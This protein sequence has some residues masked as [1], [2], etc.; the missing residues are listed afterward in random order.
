V[1]WI[2]PELAAACLVWWFDGLRSQERA[3]ESS[4]RALVTRIPPTPERRS[5][6]SNR[7]WPVGQREERSASRA[8]RSWP[9]RSRRASDQTGPNKERIATV[10]GRPRL[11]AW[12][13]ARG[14][15]ETRCSKDL[16]DRL[17]TKPEKAAASPLLTFYVN[18]GN[19]GAAL[20]PEQLQRIYTGELTTPA[21][22]GLR[23]RA[24]SLSL[25]PSGQFGSDDGAGHGVV[26]L[27]RYS[28]RRGEPQDRA[29]RHHMTEGV[30][31]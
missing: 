18:E 8:T 16:C 19:P 27:G 17:V 5:D 26:G 7:R 31:R 3:A 13:E 2:K 12:H 10:P 4:E 14:A 22:G 23:H 20:T 29:C 25:A 21:D 28:H 6:C 9:P 11:V 24:L 15:R 30:D 1:D